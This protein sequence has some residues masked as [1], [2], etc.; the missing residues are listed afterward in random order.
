MY[1]LL[2]ECPNGKS[3]IEHLLVIFVIKPKIILF[4]CIIKATFLFTY[5]HTQIHTQTQ[6]Q[7]HTQEHRIIV[8]VMGGEKKRLE[9]KD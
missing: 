2:Y 3:I 4:L 6:T 1:I 5:E 7:T 8:Q 9:K